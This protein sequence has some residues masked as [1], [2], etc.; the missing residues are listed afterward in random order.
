MK[1]LYDPK[2][3]RT[4]DMLPLR[5]TDI[6]FGDEVSLTKQSDAAACDINN[7]M[8][9]YARMDMRDLLQ[10]NP[11]Q[12][13]DLTDAKTYHESMNIVV[14]AQA[15][16]EALPANIRKKFGNDP[17]NFLEFCSN[18]DNADEMVELGLA[19]APADLPATTLLEPSSKRPQKAG[20]EEGDPARKGG[21]DDSSK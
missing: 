20:V 1:Q 19:E 8:A 15:A 3:I 4:A 7:I 13:L 6:D 18:P 9:P 14:E 16:F 12:Y 10:S 17:E 11:G 2:T 5:D 21:N